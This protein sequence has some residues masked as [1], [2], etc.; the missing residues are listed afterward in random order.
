MLV[1]GGV[2]PRHTTQRGESGGGG[3]KAVRETGAQLAG[4]GC[5]LQAVGT[6]RGGELQV[7]GGVGGV[8]V[9]E[10]VLER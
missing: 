7:K 6:G 8:V 10:M 1:E 5:S 2:T 4:V 3:G 9:W